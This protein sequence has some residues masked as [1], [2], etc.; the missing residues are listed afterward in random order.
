MILIS[1]LTVYPVKG[2]RGI[3][4]RETMVEPRGL[5]GD[6]RWMLIDEDNTFLS[7]RTTPRMCL[8]KANLSE[9]R[10]HVEAPNGESLEVGEPKG[11][12]VR[13]R[14]WQDECDAL[15]VSSQADAWFS[16]QL[17]IPCRL[18]YM[19]DDSIRPTNPNYT[20][21]GDHVGFADGFPI[22]VAS[23]ASLE[24]LNS[25]LANPLP[26]NR[27][28]PNLLV[29]GCEAFA[30]DEWPSFEVGGTRFRAAK[31][32]VRCGVTTTDQDTAEIGQEPLRTLA[33]YRREGNGVI[34]GSFFVPESFGQLTLGMELR[35][36]GD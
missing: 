10:L 20:R 27:F 35:P 32:C 2:L 7:Q 4:R 33:T 28:R 34:F 29:S 30:E 15:L 16:R 25:R 12:R 22:L 36:S 13:V 24:D 11:A 1:G 17:G 23:Q 18:V 6:R 26:M 31:H 8:Y 21:A 14:V 19:P 3:E 9:D 5:A